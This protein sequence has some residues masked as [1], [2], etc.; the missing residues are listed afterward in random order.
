MDAFASNELLL[1]RGPIIITFGHILCLAMLLYVMYLI[2][3]RNI[4]GKLMNTRII[5]STIWRDWTM[6]GDYFPSHREGDRQCISR[7]DNA[8]SLW[9]FRDQITGSKTLIGLYDTFR[10]AANAADALTDA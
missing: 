8:Y 4:R 2:A 7:R 3:K 10:Q 1:D 5:N 9:I 6:T